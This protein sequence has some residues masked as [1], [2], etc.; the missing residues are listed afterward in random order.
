L[1]G[2]LEDGGIFFGTG[3]S[4]V[5]YMGDHFGALV[6]EAFVSWRGG[7]TRGFGDA[8]ACYIGDL[9]C[10]LMVPTGNCG[11]L[12]FCGALDGGLM[13]PT[14]TGTCGLFVG[15]CALDCR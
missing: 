12:T 1:V 2:I 14:G 7:P 15:V 4:V 5:A 9:D 6:M 3:A 10:G 11:L 13:V 8:V